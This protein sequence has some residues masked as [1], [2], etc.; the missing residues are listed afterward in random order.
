[1]H[2]GTY[3]VYIG[4]VHAYD[5]QKPKLQSQYSKRLS[6]MLVP[7]LT[8]AWRVVAGMVASTPAR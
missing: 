5:F 4:Y 6:S 2:Q 3:V 1:M 8:C 7:V